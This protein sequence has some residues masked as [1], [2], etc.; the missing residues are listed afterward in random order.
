MRSPGMKTRFHFPTFLRNLK[1]SFV[2]NHVEEQVTLERRIAK[3]E[4]L[5]ERLR[6]ENTSYRE[7]L[8]LEDV[9]NGDEPQFAEEREYC[10]RHGRLRMF[11]YEKVREF[12]AIEVCFDQAKG[13]PYVVHDGKRLYYPAAWGTG[14]ITYNYLNSVAV[15]GILGGGCLAKSP[16]N[17]LDARFPV[18][19]G[20]V[21]CDFGAAEG[22]VGWHLA[23][24]ASRIVIGECDEKWL[25]PLKATFEPYAEKTVFVTE[26]LGMGGGGGSC[27]RV[28][29][30]LR[31]DLNPR[32]PFFLKFDIEGAERFAIREAEGFFRDQ[33]DVTVACAAYH[34]HDDGK[35]LEELFRGW[36]YETAFSNGA[37]L[38]LPDRLVPPYFRPG[39]VYARKDGKLG[40][41]GVPA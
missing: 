11:P 36:G 32:M 14:T 34:R 2:R 29:E 10:R 9:L 21:V 37:M 22:L 12:P 13:L 1:W 17:Y 7:L 41:G 30:K 24:R 26:P 38:V 39:V 35:Q 16:H 8:L 15:E 4:G 33:G 40:A 18:R 20:A 27:L 23:E 25:P 6:P 3:L 5:V 28:L 31:A 19:D